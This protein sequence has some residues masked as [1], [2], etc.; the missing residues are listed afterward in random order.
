MNGNIL[1]AII[2]YKYAWRVTALLSPSKGISLFFIWL[3]TEILDEQI[4]PCEGR[5]NLRVV[6]KTRAKFPS[7]KPIHRGAGRK[8][9]IRSFWIVVNTL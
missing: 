8:N 9:E 6:K 5:S 7:K 2:Q 4:P 1:I 3:K